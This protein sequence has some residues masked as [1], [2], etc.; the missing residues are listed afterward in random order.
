M[1]TV[2]FH[3]HSRTMPNKICR[4]SWSLVGSYSM[5]AKSSPGLPPLRRLIR[6]AWGLTEVPCN[7]NS[8][9]QPSLSKLLRSV[10]SLSR[11]HL[12][13]SSSATLDPVRVSNSLTRSM[14]IL[15]KWGSFLTPT[16]KTR[17]CSWILYKY[18]MQCQ[19]ILC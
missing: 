6:I 16:Y 19:Y 17:S 12:Y 14:V 8:L 2:T 1:I 15:T 18:K 3:V 9:R 7:L 5:R 11:R 4:K 10:V 13:G